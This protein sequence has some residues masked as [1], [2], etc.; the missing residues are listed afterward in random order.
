M[1]PNLG[2]KI[3][4]PSPISVAEFYDVFAP[5]WITLMGA[6]RVPK[7]PRIGIF[8]LLSSLLKPL[9]A[10]RHRCQRGRRFYG[11]DRSLCC[12]QKLPSS[13]AAL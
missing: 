7:I 5:L 9:I 8:F 13:E 12:S 1:M 4:Q 11:L 3:L 10:Y 2:S 6:V